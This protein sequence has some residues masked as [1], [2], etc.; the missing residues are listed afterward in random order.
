MISSAGSLAR[1]ASS[2]RSR[3]RVAMPR[4][5]APCRASRGSI[6]APAA[7]C[8]SNVGLSSRST[9][10]I[11]PRL[12]TC[13][14]SEAMRWVYRPFFPEEQ[15]AMPRPWT[16]TRHDPIEK[17]DEN[18]WGVSGDVP[19][20]P[21]A[22]RFHRRMQIVKLSNGRLVF[23]N[24]VPLGDAALAEVRAWGKPSILIVPHHLHALDAFGFQAKLGLS[25]FTASPAVEKV[26][27][28]V[29]VDGTLDE[30]PEDPAL[31]CE[32]LKGTKFGEAAYVVRT[33]PR[34]RL[35]FCDAIMNSRPGGGF[36]GFMFRLLGVS[37][38][39][40]EHTSELQSL[41]YL[42]CRLL[43]E[44]KKKNSMMSS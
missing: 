44:K 35:S 16:V 6:S 41:A 4:I 8:T 10:T 2:S 29:K 23:H 43:L 19:G 21:R 34:A 26:R 7:R 28:I 24:A 22:A 37:G 11:S 3:P 31:R 18:L 27:A 32:P 5:A 20:F 42:V 38:R 30:L 39:S 36:S 25:V 15:P 40:E 1:K 9:S 13:T 17:I 12:S 33:G 14:R